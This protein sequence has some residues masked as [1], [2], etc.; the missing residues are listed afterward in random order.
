VSKLIILHEEGEDRKSDH[1]THTM[2]SFN[3]FIVLYEPCYVQVSKL[4]IL[5]EEGEDGNAMPD[6]QGPVQAETWNKKSA[7]H[8]RW[9]RGRTMTQKRSEVVAIRTGCGEN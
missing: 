4:I 3:P 7:S 5:H 2:Y 1:V 8:Q 9:A 6:L